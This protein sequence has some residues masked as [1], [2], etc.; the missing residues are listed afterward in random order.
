M[1]AD[2]GAI[3]SSRAGVGH[4]HRIHAGRTV[5][6][7]HTLTVGAYISHMAR[8]DMTYRVVPLRSAEAREIPRGSTVSERLEMVRE[9]S[10]M[11]WTASGRVFP[12]YTRSEM[13]VR[14]STLNDQGAPGER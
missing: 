2:D 9:L 10:R 5:R 7:A 13:P 11:A 6:F 14:L 1:W 12:R 8:R 3:S 4:D